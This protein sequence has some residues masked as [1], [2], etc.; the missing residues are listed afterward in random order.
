MLKARLLDY[1]LACAARLPLPALRRSGAVLGWVL[2]ACRGRMAQV[3]IEN[4]R[5]CYPEFDTAQQRALARTSL[6]ETGKTI[7]ET[8]FAWKAPVDT[9]QSAIIKVDNEHIVERAMQRGKGIIFVMPH[10]GNWEMLNHYLGAE[11]GLTHM[12]LPHSN[13]HLNQLINRYRDRTGTRFVGVDNAGVRA[14][15]QVLRAG[16]SIGT[17]PDQ[18]PDVHTGSFSK[19]FGVSALTTNLVKRFVEKTDCEAILTHCTRFGAGFRVV[20]APMGALNESIEDAVRTDPGIYLWSYKRFRSRPEGEAER[21]RFTQSRPRRVAESIC[22]HLF[23]N[24]SRLLDRGSAGL[25]ASVVAGIM[26]RGRVDY[27]RVAEKNIAACL[28]DLPSAAR[29]DLA[30]QA[31]TELVRICLETGRT[32]QS[33]DD[34]FCPSV[35]GVEHLSGGATMVLTPPLGNREMVMRHLG[36]H[37]NTM[38]YY[39]PNSSTALDAMIRRQRTR[40]G[41]ALVEHTRPGQQALVQQLNRGDVITLCPDQQPKLRGGEFVP[42]FGVPA[43]TS[44]AMASILS[45]SR[46]A[47]VFGVAIHDGSS[48]QLHFHPCRYDPCAAPGHILAGINSQLADIIQRHQSQYRWA[49]KRFNIRP[50]GMAK[51]YH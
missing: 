38:E 48:Y 37:F 12:S 10:L 8:V 27:V 35:Q 17:M 39:H 24:A 13:P 50:R 1:L 14:Q 31:T 3:S 22:L 49:D 28:P 2:W 30:Q 4:I 21:Y 16:G 29:S 44:L 32:W 42:F 26:N 41:I 47:L 36:C 9:C 33:S 15:L 40:M 45:E 19:F 25:L 23:C 6:I 7:G 18:E 5:L 34:G 11:Y 43:L 46:P 51:I 20:F